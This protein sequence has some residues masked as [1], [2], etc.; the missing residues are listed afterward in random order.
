MLLI[1]L[2]I[3]VFIFF[4][5]LL[6]LLFAINI[7]FVLLLV[8]VF[9]FIG[10]M[11][12]VYIWSMFWFGVIFEWSYNMHAQLASCWFYQDQGQRI[13]GEGFYMDFLVVCY[14]GHTLWASLTVCQ[15]FTLFFNDIIYLLLH[16]STFSYLSLLVFLL[17][18]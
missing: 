18:L 12:L 14:G 16:I 2:L 7:L 11:L 3:F 6:L 8:N 9:L 17:I 13:S 4:I 15:L 5:P 1:L 10:F